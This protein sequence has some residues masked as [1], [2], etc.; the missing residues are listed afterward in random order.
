M[1]TLFISD[2]H[3]S[4]ERPDLTTLFLEFLGRQ[5]KQAQA[6]YILGDLFEFWVGDDV[7]LEDDYRPIT[8]G[9][10]QLTRSGVPVYFAH[11]NRDFLLGNDYAKLTGIELLPEPACIDLYG[12]PVL[13][14]HGDIL[15]TDDHEY[16]QFRAMIRSPEW[17]QAFL[18]NSLAKRHQIFHEYRRISMEVSA[19]KKPEIMDVNQQAVEAMMQQ[20]QVGLMIHGHTH[21]PAEHR[22]KLGDT[23]AVRIVLSDWDRTG[24]VLVVDADGWRIDTLAL[25]KSVSPS[26]AH[27]A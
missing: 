16:Q 18:A 7:A 27:E 13:L 17:Q 3:L 24:S 5:A 4:R 14:L 6:V 2:L 19:S 25:P 8:E 11:G 10:Q 23:E 1:A 12:R 22:F 20:H 26:K 9:L 15:C 21:R